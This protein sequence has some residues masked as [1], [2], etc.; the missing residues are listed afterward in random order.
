MAPSDKL[1]ELRLTERTLREL[2]PLVSP[3]RQQRLIAALEVVRQRIV[4]I[5]AEDD[6]L[7]AA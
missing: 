4:E 7:Q 6:L 2:I 5:D 1:R 3:E